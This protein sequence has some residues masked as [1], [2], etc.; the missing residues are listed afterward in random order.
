VQLLAAVSSSW[1]LLLGI[2]FIMLGNGLQGT[3]LGV[4]AT[5]AGFAPSTTG[6][7]MAAYYVGFLAGSAVVPRLLRQVGHVRVFAALASLASAAVLLHYLFVLGAAW[8]VFRLATGFAY[9]GLYIVAESWLND[10]AQPE[11]RSELLAVYMLISL[12][13]LGLGQLLLNAGDPT[14]AD[15]YILVSV[16]ISVALIPMALTAT[17]APAYEAPGKIGLRELYRVSP[18]GV[19]GCLVVGMSYGALFG[20][21]AVYASTMGLSVQQISYF[22]GIV[23]LG[24]IALQWPLGRL[25]DAFDRRAVITVVTFAASATSLA[26]V[27]VS[28]A[29]PAAL[30]VLMCLYGGLS[31]PLYSLCVAYTNDYLAVDQMV[32]G[33]STIVLVRGIGAII[34]PLAV[35]GLMAYGGPDG[36][37]WFLGVV[38]AALGLF[39]LYRMTRRA[40]PGVEAQHQYPVVEPGAQSV[41][42][43]AAMRTVRESEVA[44]D[45]A[46]A[47]GR[48]TREEPP[49][50]GPGAP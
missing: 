32:S 29:S 2:G 17:R 48:S 47:Q 37:L 4:G 20:M 18:L 49:P 19:I 38:H 35:G 41:V 25:G 15:L 1:A 40:S 27:P 44:E 31:L 3:L 7:V 33:S 50:G 24:G 12:A 46:R 34:G 28:H 36:F 16:L 13:G 22:M 11:T 26:S 14:H 39:A 21:G 8:F 5:I 23:L 10:R 6:V 9:A 45:A 30:L 43:S 42:M